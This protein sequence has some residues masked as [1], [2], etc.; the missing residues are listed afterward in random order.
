MGPVTTDWYRERGLTQM[1]KATVLSDVISR[2]TCRNIGETYEVEDITQHYSAGRIDIYGLDEKEYYNGM[3]EYGIAPMKTES[4]NLLTD[5]LDGLET[6]RL[7]SYNDLIKRF[8]NE[9][10]HK[11]KWAD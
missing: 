1:K 8:E 4:W 5:W 7:V 11:I 10:G 3:S 9:T 6:E 2:I